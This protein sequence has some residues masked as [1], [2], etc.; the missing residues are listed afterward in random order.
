MTSSPSLSPTETSQ[1]VET[2][3]AASPRPQR[4]RRGVPPV[5]RLFSGGSEAPPPPA[6]DPTTPAAHRIGPDPY[7]NGSLS[8]VESGPSDRDGKRGSAGRSTS[9]PAPISRKRLRQGIADSL[10]G[11]SQLAN[12]NL[13]RDE[14]EEQAG[15]YLMSD[16]QAKLIGDPAGNMAARR[17]AAAGL[18][19]SPDVMDAI[20]IV[21]GFAA[22]VVQQLVLRGAIRRH[23]RQL[24]AATVAVELEQEAPPA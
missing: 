3:V 8:D 24:A 21:A 16:D 5:D 10:Q 17:M 22:Y 23:R 19:G 12:T 7:A 4:G 2:P 20:Q 13:S 9:K 18:A 11:A 14:L 1:P 6:D 15:L